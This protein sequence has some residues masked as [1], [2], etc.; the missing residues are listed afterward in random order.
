MY[1]QHI[2]M[3]I[4]FADKLHYMHIVIICQHLL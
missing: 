3:I 1:V 4:I 2:Y